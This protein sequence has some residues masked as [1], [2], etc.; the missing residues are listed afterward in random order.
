MSSMRF[1]TGCRPPALELRC[2]P[3]STPPLSSWERPRFGPRADVADEA[4]TPCIYVLAGTNGAG[5]SSIQGARLLQ[6]G[7]QH[8]NPDAAAQRIL[9]AD[10]TTA[11]E[12][13]KGLAWQE[14]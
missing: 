11:Q 4:A 3:R 8:F 13:A 6:L 2:R 7:L 14:G 12:A 10:P 9:C 1:S 5:K